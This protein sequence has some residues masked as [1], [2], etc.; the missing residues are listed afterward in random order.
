MFA[1][2]VVL[3]Q[4]RNFAEFSVSRGNCLCQSA[5]GIRTGL[6]L[7]RSELFHVPLIQPMCADLYALLITL[8]R[9]KSGNFCRP[10]AFACTSPQLPSKF[11]VFLAW[12]KWQWKIWEFNDLWRHSATMYIAEAKCLMSQYPNGPF[13][14]CSRRKRAWQRWRTPNK[15]VDSGDIEG[16]RKERNGIRST[17]RFELGS[18]K[19]GL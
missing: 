19:V 2:G 18:D 13:V 10:R 11:H 8:S 4:R 3:T 9:Q 17:V 6:P 5:T 1:D 7:K 14:E 12:Q 15:R 16:R